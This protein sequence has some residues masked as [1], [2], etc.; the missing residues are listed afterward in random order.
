MMISETSV[1]DV[2]ESV[3]VSLEHSYTTAYDLGTNAVS[4]LFRLNENNVAELFEDLSHLTLD[5][6][7][8]LSPDTVS[9]RLLLFL[10]RIFSIASDYIPDHKMYTEEE[11]FQLGML[12]YSEYQLFIR[13]A[14]PRIPLVIQNYE[15]VDPAWTF[16]Y[17]RVYLKAFYS[18]GFSYSQYQV[19]QANGILRW[20]TLAPFTNIA[21][22]REDEESADYM[23]LLYRGPIYHVINRKDD[24][25][26]FHLDLCD[27]KINLICDS[28]S[29]RRLIEDKD[30][31]IENPSL[32]RLTTRSSSLSSSSSQ[33]FPSRSL[34][35][36]GAAGAMLLE[37]NI[38]RLLDLMKDDDEIS[39]CMKH[40]LLLGLEERLSTSD[41]DIT[42]DFMERID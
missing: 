17:R 41:W 7:T 25:R 11:F 42:Q 37:M 31:G 18:A 28:M 12:T 32:Y 33:D 14:L 34:L 2:V 22:G 16:R 15:N 10:G 40:L 23:Y 26:A 24:Q 39:R 19:L 20:V 38:Q 27:K 35:Q 9:L 1:F 3:S 4:S 5:L 6:A 36:A 13:S 30:Q 21:L 8:F 29:A